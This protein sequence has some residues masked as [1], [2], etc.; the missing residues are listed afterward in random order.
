FWHIPWPNPETFSIC[1]WREEIIDGLL[2]SSVL[3]FHT[4][5]HCNNFLETVD[6]FLECR[7]D[8]ETSTISYRGKLTAIRH[9]PIS[10]DWPSR[11]ANS[12]ISVAQCRDDIRARHQLP[13]EALIGIGVDRL[14]Y[15]KGIPE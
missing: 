6:R 5:F 10:I 14:D 9:Y 12:D 13:K 3:G 4:R 11:W 8:R 7:I 2:G 15:T 1:P